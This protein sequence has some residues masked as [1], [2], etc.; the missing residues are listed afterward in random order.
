MFSNKV[1]D[2]L[3]KVIDKNKL[4]AEVHIVFKVN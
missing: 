3:Q 2:E 4:S 1:V